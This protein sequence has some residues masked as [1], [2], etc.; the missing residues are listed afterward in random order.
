VARNVQFAGSISGNLGAN[1][2]AT[3]GILAP[4]YRPVVTKTF[5]V[6]VTAGT[7]ASGFGFLEIQAA[8]AVNLRPAIA[9]SELSLDVVWSLD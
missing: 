2:L 1:A 3:L 9:M 4:A 6:A 5:A 8:G 7:L